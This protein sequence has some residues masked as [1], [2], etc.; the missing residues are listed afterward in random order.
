M[1]FDTLFGPY[2]DKTITLYSYDWV[3]VDSATGYVSYD[4]FAT[5]DSTS[6]KYVLEK[7][8]EKSN[9]FSFTTCSFGSHKVYTMVGPA[10]YT[11]LTKALDLDFDTSIF[12]KA[13]TIRGKA[14]FKIPF[15]GNISSTV[16]NSIDVY[17]VVKLRKWNGATETEIVS[18]QSPTHTSDFPDTDNKVYDFFVMSIDV[19]ETQIAINEQI[20]LTVELW[21]DVEND[22]TTYA[23]LHHDPQNDTNTYGTETRLIFICPFK[24]DAIPS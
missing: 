5:A 7:S 15:A 10:D 14:C 19:P 22:A 24:I 3:D 4:G 11:T 2:Q 13:R 6:I 21:V 12:K 16:N 17:V 20:R 1:N 18:V 9:L 8:S 23:L